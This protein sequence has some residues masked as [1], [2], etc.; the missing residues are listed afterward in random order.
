[1]SQQLATVPQDDRR[2]NYLIDSIDNGSRILLMLR[3]HPVIRAA[4]VARE[5]GV[6]RSTAHRMVSTLQYR[7]LLRQ[8]PDKTYSAGHSLM[9]LGMAVIG[10]TD[11]RTESQPFLESLASRSGETAHLLI[12]EGTESV[13]AAGAESTRVIRAALR[14]GTRFPAHVTAAGRCL[15]AALPIEEVKQLFPSPRLSGGTN[16]AIH[17]RSELLTVL[18]QVR[19]KGYA[20]NDS[21]SEPDLFAIAMPLVDSRGVTRA[22]ITLS[23]PAERMRNS[24]DHLRDELE[25]TV[26]EF[27]SKVLH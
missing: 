18:Q 21:E 22:A 27:S 11:L 10:A 24:V 26:K 23:G 13:F 2:N 20:V 8:N 4:D 1:M 6:A 14:I 12:L 7:G 5:L 3:D 16:Q 19:E 17:T 15:L 25:A 9:E